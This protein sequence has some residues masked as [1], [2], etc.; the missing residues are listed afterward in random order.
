MA[1]HKNKTGAITSYIKETEKSQENISDSYVPKIGK[2]RRNGYISRNMQS[3]KPK[4]G[5]IQSEYTYIS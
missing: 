1:L 5:N 3:S 2:P 4:S